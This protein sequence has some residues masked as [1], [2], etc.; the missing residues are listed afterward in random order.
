MNDLIAFAL[1]SGALGLGV[2]GG[3]LLRGPLGVR[4]EMSRRF[5][6][7]Y[8]GV[9][10]AI[11][12]SF[13]D[14]PVW[15]YVLCSVFVAVNLWAVPRRV[16]RG[17]HDIQ[18][19][20]WGTVVFPLALIFALWTCWT[21]DPARIFALRIAF[22][23]LA[24]SDPLAS[25]IGSTVR[26]PGAFVVAGNHKSVAGSAAF[27]ASAFALSAGGLAWLG[28]FEGWSPL[29]YAGLGLV[30]ATLSTVA[31]LLGSRGWD[32]LAIVVAVVTPLIAL[33]GSPEQLGHL[34][35]A[36]SWAVGF[37]LVSLRLRFLDLSGALAAGLLAFAVVGLGGWDWALPGFAFFL[38]SSALSKV[39]RKRKL[40]S[41][42]GEKGSRRDAGQV[43][44]N[45]GLAA[46]L[47]LW[48]VFDPEPWQYWGFVGAFAAAAADTW[49]TEI[50]TYFRAPTRSVW[51]WRRVP[52][53]MSGGVSLP[54][55]LGGLAGA[56]TVFAPI[57]FFGAERLGALGWAPALLVVVAGGFVASLVDSLLGATAQALYREP[58]S[59]AL[60]EQP[61]AHGRD[62]LLVKGWRWL[63]N[64]RVNLAC[65]LAG[66]L[67]VA[68]SSLRL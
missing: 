62:N 28:P 10:V 40:A 34:L 25:L 58:T 20:S 16:F 67:L 33:Q 22:V 1:F 30:V 41:V 11:A 17:M 9:A 52:V 35:S 24:L 59:Q 15:I 6:H 39:G 44:A 19:D 13:F 51:T 57:P 23:V 31:E 32:N 26:D 46:A 42:K 61:A 48:N 14:T 37:G 36:C 56:A 49:S 50:G 68:V 21:L 18:R 65:T 43:Y 60:T 55:T 3:E 2:A 12:P 47:L 53:G 63:N 5:V 8:T 45:G 64:D 54:G 66:A 4:P 7:A 27:F 38:L 29:H